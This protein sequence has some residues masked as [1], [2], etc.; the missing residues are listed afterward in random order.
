MLTPSRDSHKEKEAE[1]EDEG[2]STSVVAQLQAQAAGNIRNNQV[3][4][5][6]IRNQVSLFVVIA[7]MIIHPASARPTAR[8]VIS[9]ELRITLPVYAERER[10][11]TGQLSKMKFMFLTN[12]VT[13]TMLLI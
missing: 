4:E 11:K 3:R 6:D 13:L 10:R 2:D 9:V 12:P 1:V 7:D 8:N 5:A